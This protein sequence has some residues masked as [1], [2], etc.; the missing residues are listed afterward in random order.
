MSYVLFPSVE[1]RDC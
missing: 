1:A